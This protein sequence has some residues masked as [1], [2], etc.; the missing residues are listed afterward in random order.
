MSKLFLLPVLVNGFLAI[1]RTLTAVAA[2]R[3]LANTM[4]KRKGSK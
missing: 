3:F 2:F 1:P 4:V